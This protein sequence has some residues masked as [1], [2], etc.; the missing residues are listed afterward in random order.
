MILSRSRSLRVF[1][2]RPLAAVLMVLS[3]ISC[4]GRSGVVRQAPPADRATLPATAAGPMWSEPQFSSMLQAYRQQLP[5]KRKALEFEIT[6]ERARL[7][8][9]DPA[10]PQ[11]VDQYEYRQGRLTGP[12]PVQLMGE[13]DHLGENLFAW[14]EVAA[15]RIPELAKTALAKVPIEDG[16]IVQVRVGRG[17]VHREVH[18]SVAL[19]GPR[20]FGGL[21]ADSKGKVLT[22]EKN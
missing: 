1:P 14:D 20:G 8:V 15:E 21:T 12:T 19:Q 3:F 18:I 16:R 2:A 4:N 10:K 13:T 9:Q 5:G 6:D 22:V 7:Q 17:I 11:N